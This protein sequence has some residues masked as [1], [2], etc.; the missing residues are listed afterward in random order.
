MIHDDPYDDWA[1][2]AEGGIDKSPTERRLAKAEKRV[3]DLEKELNTV[4]KV[5]V[6]VMET[7]AET[8][9]ED[10]VLIKAPNVRAWWADYRKAE[11]AR[12]RYWMEKAEETAEEQ[13]AAYVE[14]NDHFET[15]KNKYE[16]LKRKYKL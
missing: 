9:Q 13:R 8:G 11:L 15:A 6:E 4:K 16:A 3:K 2:F 7:L 14:H 12:A 10:F 5:A 1:D